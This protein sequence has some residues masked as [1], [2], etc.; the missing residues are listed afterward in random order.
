MHNGEKVFCRREQTLGSRLGEAK[1]CATAK[2][3]KVS[4]QETHDVIEKIQRTQ[5][6]PAGG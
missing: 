6:N 2:Q 1:H 4:Q 3:L 5:K